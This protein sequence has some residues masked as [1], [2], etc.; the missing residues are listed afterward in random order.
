MTN[1]DDGCPLNASDY[2]HCEAFVEAKS[3]VTTKQSMIKPRG[4]K[5]H[6]PIHHIGVHAPNDAK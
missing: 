6:Q 2:V 3:C 1:H 4:L 5:D